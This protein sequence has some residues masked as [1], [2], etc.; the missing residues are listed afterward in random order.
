MGLRFLLIQRPLGGLVVC[1]CTAVVAG[2]ALSGMKVNL[3]PDTRYPFITITTVL[4]GT[5]P[6]EIETL[7]T[8]KIEQATADIPGLKEL[9]ST[10]R[11]GESEVTLKFHLGR[12]ISKAASEVRGRM[13]RLR[14]SLPRDT[15]FPVITR[16][17]P[18]DAPMAVLGV[19]GKWSLPEIGHWVRH[20][21]KPELNRIKGVAAVRIAGAPETEI[22]VDC[23]PEKL[24]SLEMTVHDVTKAIDR[25][26]KSLSGGSLVVDEKTVPVRTAGN[27][28][29]PDEIAGQPLTVA[30][31]G[32]LVNVR[33]VAEVHR[34]P[35]PPRESTRHN[36]KPLVSVSI[37]QGGGA[38][39]RT[40]WQSILRT[41]AEIGTRSPSSPDVEVIYSQAE[42]LDTALSRLKG[43]L[44]L[45]VGAAGVILFL[46]LGSLSST[47]IV[48]ASVPFS[49]LVAALFMYMLRIPLDLLSMSGLVLAAGMLV[50][51]AVVVV[52]S[53][54]RQRAGSAEE[55]VWSGIRET[56]V[57]V[58]FST[59]T[60]VM[61]FFPLVFV[62]REIRMYYAGLTWSVCLGLTASLMA[63]LVLVPLLL[64]YV[65]SSAK[66][67]LK[68]F[69]E[70]AVLNRGYGSILRFTT[71]K[72][73]AA[74][75]AALVL[76]AGAGMAAPRL[77]FRDGG[78]LEERAF[79]IAVVMPPGTQKSVTE[80]RTSEIEET[81]M[82][83]EGVQSVHGKVWANQ[84][85]I[86]VSLKDKNEFPD[87]SADVRKRLKQLLP[88]V[89]AAQIHVL[90]MER[91]G[92]DLIVSLI[93]SGS[94]T[95]RLASYAK[96]VSK[97]LSKLPGVE[98]V[99]V[100]Q[101]DPIPTLEFIVRHDEVGYHGV[102]AKRLADHLRGHFTGPV[103]ARVFSSEREV[104]VRVR[105]M[106][107]EEEG[108]APV[109]NTFVR[110][111][112]G[113][114]IPLTALVQTRTRW[115]PS[116]IQRLNHRRMVKISVYF[117]DVNAL[118][119]AEDL[120]QLVSRTKLEPGYALKLGGEID[121]IIETRR[122]MIYAAAIAVLL[123]YLVLVSATE[124]FLLPLVITA[125]VP[126]AAAGV[127]AA[128]ASMGSSISRPV[129]MAMIILCGLV[130]NVN[131]LIVHSARCE[132]MNGASPEEAGR[133]GAKKRLRPVLITTLTTVVGAVPMLLDRGTGS[134][135]WAPFA[136][137]LAAGL[138]VAAPASLILTP[139]LYAAA[140]NLR[141]SVRKMFPGWGP[142]GR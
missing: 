69:S 62:S 97:D 22:I 78:G 83:L 135:L 130:I 2:F 106:R 84:A 94:D 112:E 27:L 139:A 76:L 20:T 34:V 49:L 67:P 50:D 98:N 91:S 41:L 136:L 7:V 55:S 1:I 115:V 114:M 70:A 24:K 57:P 100:H 37:Y 125:A 30:G 120:N 39:M 14:P 44:V 13:R 141:S 128:H 3:L 19:T 124:S 68:R 52:E 43:V 87:S 35:V 126:F 4:S 79:R 82:S 23:R 123:T 5:G 15:R 36:G 72:P 45:S 92:Q 90:P 47:A 140:A 33:T 6:E 111:L 117:G 38:D 54:S 102:D 56:A 95:A 77:S 109:R 86:T 16:F 31:H 61:V 121:K 108:L 25:G 40:L 11:E 80:A 26:H 137:T 107:S 59:L 85:R 89:D 119:P 93:L 101:G 66:T 103:A 122:E 12:D 29:S 118:K 63:A 18:S 51:N 132:E 28:E 113:R 116:E 53:V 133:R 88:A 42:D 8:R 81:V 10:S 96:T 134:S 9:R 74:I 60:T 105:G 48:M 75:A 104:L 65:P 58:L 46:F 129:Y 131:I 110:N 21:L 99:L 32:G 71:A 64:R 73:W 142:G 17:N 127:V 138:A